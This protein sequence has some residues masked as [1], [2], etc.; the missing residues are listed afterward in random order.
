MPL[1]F[2]NLR[3]LFF[4]PSSAPDPLPI[5][6]IHFA[7]TLARH[8]SLAL[9]S[10][11]STPCTDPGYG[12]LPSPY[13]TVAAFRKAHAATYNTFYALTESSDSS[14]SGDS[15]SDAG[16]DRDAID[17]HALDGALHSPEHPVP[18]DLQRLSL[19]DLHA[20]S[21]TLTAA[22]AKAETAYT[23]AHAAVRALW[24]EERCDGVAASPLG[25]GARDVAADAD[26][27]D[28]WTVVDVNT[29]SQRAL[30]RAAQPDHCEK[31]RIALQTCTD[32]RRNCERITARLAALEEVMA[33]KR[34]AASAAWEE[35]GVVKGDA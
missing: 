30:G 26:A 28:E 12:R 21:A 10:V 1:T 13:T 6:S 22:L 3:N 25:G 15:L 31:L 4:Q 19:G 5:P 9:A 18:R 8:D 16:S 23:E 34:M 29:G 11:C 14:D 2:P 32:A 17:Y 35:V 24:A 27:D 7:P 33:E 20:K